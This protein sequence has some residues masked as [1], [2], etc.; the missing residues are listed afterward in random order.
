M[1]FRLA[2]LAVAV[3][4]GAFAQSTS[5]TEEHHGQAPF[6]APAPINP[7]SVKTGAP[8]SADDVSEE[9][10]TLADGTHITRTNATKV[11]RDS[12]GRTRRERPLFRAGRKAELAPDWPQV[13]EIVDPVAKFKYVLDVSNKVAH[14]QQLEVEAQKRSQ[15]ALPAVREKLVVETPRPSDNYEQLGKQTIEGLVAEGG[16]STGT[17]PIGS[18]DNDRPITVVSETWRSRELGEVVLYKYN[19]PRVGEHTLKLVN[20]DLNE[21]AASLFQVPGDYTVVDEAGAF[22]ITH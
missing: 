17:I 18:Q 15:P 1:Q 21:P 14:R 10:Q 4:A 20:I 11:Y 3:C 16:R 2:V 8:Y 13:V 12:L 5:A 7:R 22:T 19:D 9:I 6:L